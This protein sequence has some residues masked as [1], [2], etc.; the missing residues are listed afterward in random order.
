MKTSDKCVINSIKK[1]KSKNKAHN[2][3][4]KKW[5]KNLSAATKIRKNNILIL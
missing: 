3:N 1:K 4:Q 5:S 2:H